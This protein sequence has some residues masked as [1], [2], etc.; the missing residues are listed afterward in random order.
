MSTCW[1]L[2]WTKS[3]LNKFKGPFKHGDSF[4]WIYNFICYNMLVIVFHITIYIK[5][6]STVMQT[7]VTYKCVRQITNY[8]LTT[9]WCYM[10]HHHT[11]G[12]IHSPK[13]ITAVRYVVKGCI[14]FWGFRA[15][16]FYFCIFLIWWL[17]MAFIWYAYLFTIGKSI[18]IFLISKVQAVLGLILHW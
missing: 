12:F 2:M 11:R 8:S 1:F 4:Y 13:T 7:M 5:I 6:Y 10:A 3:L 15:F 16:D 9:F 14:I 18:G 17:L